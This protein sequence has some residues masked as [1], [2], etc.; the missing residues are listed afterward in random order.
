MLAGV[1]PAS[2]SSWLIIVIAMMSSLY[3]HVDLSLGMIDAIKENLPYRSVIIHSP[4]ELR[5][6]L[7]CRIC[8]R[9]CG[10]TNQS[11]YISPRCAFFEQRLLV[12]ADPS[13]PER[14]PVRHWPVVVPHLPAEIHPQSSA[15]LPRMDL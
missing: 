14:D 4:E 12:G 15:L 9:S 10:I 7:D 5:Y 3:I 2:P 1:Y 11:Y 13:S 8:I 6:L